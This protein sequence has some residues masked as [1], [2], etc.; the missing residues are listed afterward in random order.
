MKNI[1]KLMLSIVSIISLYQGQTH[2][3]FR[4][5]FVAPVSTQALVISASSA[6][7]AQ[8]GYFGT[9]NENDDEQSSNVSVPN[10]E[11]LDVK[12]KLNKFKEGAK[13]VISARF[14]N[15]D[16]EKTKNIVKLG[17]VV[18]D[19]SLFWL[20]YF[21]IRG[22]FGICAQSKLR[23]FEIYE[24]GSNKD[25]ALEAYGRAFLNPGTVDIETLTEKAIDEE[26]RMGYVQAVKKR[27]YQPR[28]LILSIGSGYGIAALH[29]LVVQSKNDSMNFVG[30][31]LCGSLHSLATFLI[32]R[33]KAISEQ[34]EKEWNV[35][36][37]AQLQNELEQV[38]ASSKKEETKKIES[39]EKKLISDSYDKQNKK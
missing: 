15:V 3:M 5:R 8:R 10:I 33:K 12:N 22:F 14:E 25:P 29:A 27:M 36:D 1:N 18:S 28:A 38:I 24:K 16:I 2:G 17:L 21:A 7:V 35:S 32:L 20:A 39:N 4:R 11:V 31:E 13:G 37:L 6:F 30:G 23:K 26:N 9:N 19:P 34:K